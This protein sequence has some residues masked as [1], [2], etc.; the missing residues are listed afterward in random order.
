MCLKRIPR[1]L[2][3]HFTF[4]FSSITSINPENANQ[5]VARLIAPILNIQL[6]VAAHS[7]VACNRF[8]RFSFNFR[9]IRKERT[10]L[11]NGRREVR[12]AYRRM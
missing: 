3:S 9:Q 8:Y 1:A 10:C 6:L 4:S 2:P 7:H 12:A 5:T 11:Q